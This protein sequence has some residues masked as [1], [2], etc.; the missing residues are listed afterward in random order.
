MQTF[1]RRQRKR[2]KM[3]SLSQASLASGLMALAALAAACETRGSAEG[4]CACLRENVC[5]AASD[6]DTCV[7]DLEDG[8]TP[9]RTERPFGEGIAVNQDCE[10]TQCGD[11]LAAVLDGEGG[12]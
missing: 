1:F 5:I 12:E 10:E 2:P 11:C 8:V 7:A 6:E 9:D 3:R 4:C